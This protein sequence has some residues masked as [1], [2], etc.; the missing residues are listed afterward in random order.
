MHT[1]FFIILFLLTTNA[2]AQTY[3]ID[4]LKKMLPLLR[5]RAK[6]N[7]LN[8]LGSQ[9]YF[10]W[11]HTDSA[12]KYASLAYDRASSIQYNSGKAESLI[13]QAGV[14]G[15][16]LGHPELMEQYSQQAIGLLK[17]ENDPKNLSTAYYNLAFA[18]ALKGNYARAHD[19][20]SKSRHIAISSNEKLCLG[21]AAQTTGFIYA[22]SGEYLKAFE[23]LIE[24]QDIGKDLDDSL[25]TSF[26]L[27]FIARSFNR[28]GDPQ[29]AL[30]YYH[31]TLKFAPPFLLLW[32]HLEDMA[33]AHLQLKQ[34]DSVVYYQQKHKQ[35]LVL[36]TTDLLLQKKFGFTSMGFSVDIQLAKKQYD[37]VLAQVLPG[38]DPLRKNKDIIPYMQVLLVLGKVYEGKGNYQTSLGYARELFQ[39]ASNVKNK[40]FLKDADQLLFTLF[41]RLK[42]TD[43]AYFYFRH[44]TTI[45]DSMENAQ[46]ARR[47]ALYLAASEAEN[48]IRLLKK[49]KKIDEQRLALN[50][51][52]LQKQGQ[53]KNLMAAGLIVLFLFSMMVVRNII[54][55]R[56]NE[57]LQND[58]V[59]MSLKRKALE[60]EMQA[61]R[62]Q[63][64]PHFIFNCLSAIDDLIQ[65]SQSDKAT[66]YLARFANLIR[67]VLDSSKNNLVPFQ[68]D[69]E[70]LKLYLEMEQFRCNN[71][72]TYDLNADPELLDG[73]YK[74]PPLIIQPFVE[75]AIHHGLLNK[76]NTNRQLHITA[77]LEDEHIVYSVTDNGVGRKEAGIIR[78]MN[79]PGQQSYGIAI[80]RERIHLHNKKCFSGDVLITDL[81]QEG[82]PAGTKAVVKIDSSE[83]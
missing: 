47:T 31:E 63:M 34:Y 33:Y 29:K 72:F 42:Q 49:E 11:I 17:M 51:E 65:T 58:Q 81:N 36:L 55:K 24:A 26:A 46:F 3:R 7:C 59:Q 27:A 53:L 35:N 78:E 23:H 54:L 2:G 25:L 67:R 57:K 1:R 19:A 52:E 40:Q 14:K 16:L 28:V 56:K 50:K 73:D 61:L 18:F 15:R 79:R 12:L 39:L 22:K 32:P 66:S 37:L 45:K 71:K 5:D 83:F 64:N 60:L 80:T 68:K 69:F 74:V 6:V 43:S 30:D 13:T 10:N 4:S 62:A 76:L 20:A 44:H 21:W 38:L 8:A 77:R 41:D 70:T 48:R 9:F 82:V 75:N